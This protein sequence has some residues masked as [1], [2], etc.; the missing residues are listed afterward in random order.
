MSFGNRIIGDILL[1]LVML[2]TADVL[3]IMPARM[4][5]VVLT[6]VYRKVLR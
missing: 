4:T 1:L 2:L 5:A 6:T 3:F